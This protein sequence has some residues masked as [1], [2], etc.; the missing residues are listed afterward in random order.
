MVFIT[1]NLPWIFALEEPGIHLIFEKKDGVYSRR[2]L[3]YQDIL[4]YSIFLNEQQRNSFKDR[5]LTNWLLDRNR[6]LWNDYSHYPKNRR[7]RSSRVEDRLDRVKANI[8]NLIDMGLLEEGDT[9]PAEKGSGTVQLYKYTTDGCLL[10]S[11][12]LSFDPNKRERANEEAYE[13]IQT[14]LRIE[15]R[16]SYEIFHSSLHKK[17]KDRGVFGEFVVD[18]LRQSV[19][20][21]SEIKTMRELQYSSLVLFHTNDAAKARPYLDLW[22]ETFDEMPENIQELLLYDIKLSIERKMLYQAK[23][24]KTYE[25]ARL[26]FKEFPRVLAVEGYCNNCNLS[27]PIA[28]NTR[29][30][31]ERTNFLPNK[32]MSKCLQCKN[33]SVSVPIF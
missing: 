22:N 15:P 11:I 28:A 23:S 16:A 10:A 5:E 24:V 7:P 2:A 33:I 13:S 20:S 25:E 3:F 4:L 8:E 1:I 18:R 14:I 6:E 29:D 30:Y 19:E 27:Y 21:Y 9:A 26:K 31:L 12:I 17:Y 32:I